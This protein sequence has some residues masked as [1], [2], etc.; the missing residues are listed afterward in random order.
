M[1]TDVLILGAGLSG[2]A[3]AHYLE[4]R[5]VD[6]LLVEEKPFAGGLCT[7]E[8][9]DGYCF[10]ATG[11]WLHLRD[12]GVR[13]LVDET[14]G[15]DNYVEVERSTHIFLGGNF[16][17]YPF[18]S[19]LYGL[20]PAVQKECLKGFI[21]AWMKKKAGGRRAEPATF[22]QWVET[23][24][25]TGIARHFML[26]YNEKLWTVKASAM[27][28]LWCQIYVPIPTLDQVID[29][30]VEAPQRR[31]GYNATFLYPK[32][33]GI[34]FMTRG[35]AGSLKQPPRCGNGVAA[36]E[37]SSRTAWL[38][39]GTAVN[40]RHLV[41][42][43]PLKELVAMVLDAPDTA[44]SHARKLKHQSVCY[45]NVA[46]AAKAKVPGSN[47]IYVPE[48][49]YLFYRVGFPANA[50]ADL[51]PAG[52]DS[53]YVE[54]SHRGDL[55]AAD[56]WLQVRQDLI[57]SGILREEDIRFHQERN[58]E[59]AYVIFD[60]HYRTAV[61]ALH[62]WLNGRDIL[63]IGRYGAWTYNSMETAL[64]DG[65]AAADTVATSLGA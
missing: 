44:R 31:I 5:G 28:P 6:H 25:G 13:E 50:V 46:L 41:S 12:R 45:Y 7:S 52:T 27:T 20:P 49:E 58:I 54:V 29:G 33:G 16:T 55:P 63:S 40:F 23:H 42:S 65:R 10:D 26:P 9:Q 11:H 51:A 17:L 61:P 36:I 4:R 48:R 57:R 37:L 39:D 59:Y 3:T 21:D 34:G 43:A 56:T 19:N 38:R 1:K 15:L 53:L 47:W 2:L 18:Q 8:E 30:L 60:R 62:R 22:K 64:T 35:L 32:K 24:M 14:S